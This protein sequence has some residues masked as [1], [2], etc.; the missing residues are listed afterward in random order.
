LADRRLGFV[1]A[2]GGTGAGK[3]SEHAKGTED[4]SRKTGGSKDD[5]GVRAIYEGSRTEGCDDD[6]AEVRARHDPEG[7]GQEG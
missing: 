7:R 2:L 4:D 5:Q 6:R 3:T 1:Y